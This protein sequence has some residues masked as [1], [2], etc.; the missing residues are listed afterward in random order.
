M[1]QENEGRTRRLIADEARQLLELARLLQGRTQHQ[2][3][4]MEVAVF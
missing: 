1:T 2:V 4:S 3:D